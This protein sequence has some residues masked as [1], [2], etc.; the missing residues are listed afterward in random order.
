MQKRFTFWTSALLASAIALIGCMKSGEDAAG[1]RSGTDPVLDESHG[2]AHI[3][4]PEIDPAALEKG[5]ADSVYDTTAKAWFEL[6]ISGENMQELSYRFA[7]TGKGGQAFDI[8]GIPAGKKRSFHGRLLNANRILTHEGI[9]VADI[10]AG[11]Y[12]DVRLFLAKANGSA[13]VC[14]VIEG[15]KPPACAT[16]TLPPPVDPWPVPDSGAIAGCWQLYS[17]WIAGQVKFYDTQVNGGMGVLLRDSGEA[18]HFTTWSRQLD[19][20]AAILI[21]PDSGKKWLL[22]GTILGSGTAW[23]GTITD[24]ATGKTASFTAKTLPCGMVPEPGKTPPDS[25]PVPHK[26]DPV[27]AGSIPMPGSGGKQATLCFEMR[28]DYCTGACELSGYAKMDFL[29]GKILY[30]DL[31]VADRPGRS[32][33]KLMGLYDAGSISFYG[34][35][36]DMSSAIHDTLSLTGRIGVG[37]DMA[38]GDYLRLPSG[39]K[40]NWTMKV[41]PC[42]TW[43]PVYPDSSCF[44]TAK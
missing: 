30:G 6:A 19:T 28:F 15:Q 17:S 12:A 36:P 44:A 25:I 35:T 4:L 41:T 43:T 16:D 5:G 21:S 31:N 37:A 3:V 1:S 10:Q 27:P 26:P 11:S 18:L 40:G 8:K 34:V 38:K 13:S 42:G 9:T 24:Y 23:I 14:V 39:K 7:I 29:E 32:Y 33:T 2:G 20:L 22:R